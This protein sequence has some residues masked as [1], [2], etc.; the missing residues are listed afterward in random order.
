M[1]LNAYEQNCFDNATSFTA[2]RGLGSNR[3]RKDFNSFDDAKSYAQ[4]YNDKRTM[5]YAVTADG[6]NA[7]I[8]NI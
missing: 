4:T 5:V 7:H 6:L 2:V 1:N 8:C 3:T